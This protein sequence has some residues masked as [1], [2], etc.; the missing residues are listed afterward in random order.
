GFLSFNLNL[1]F[2]PP[3]TTGFLPIQ[4]QRA[5]SYEDAPDVPKGDFY[6]RIPQDSNITG[7]RGARNYPC[8]TRPGKRAPTVKLCESNEEYVPLNDGFNWK[9]DPNATWTG[10]DVPQLAP[11]TGPGAPPGPSSAPAPPPIAAVQ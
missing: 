9:G 1:N 7:V 6:C 2:P 5:A 8:E 3:C 11:G 10:Q 4:Q